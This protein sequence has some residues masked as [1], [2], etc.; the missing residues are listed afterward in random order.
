MKIESIKIKNYKVLRD[1]EIKNILNMAVFL[2]V[3]GSGKSTLNK[4]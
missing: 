4:K 2:G 1:L 3:N